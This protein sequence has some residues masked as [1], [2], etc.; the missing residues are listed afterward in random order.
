MVKGYR[1]QEA[2]FIRQPE[3]TAFIACFADRL[4]QLESYFG[5]MLSVSD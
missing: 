3:R 5:P 2:F 1:L 4:G